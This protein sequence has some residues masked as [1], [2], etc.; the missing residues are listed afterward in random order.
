MTPREW[1][2]QHVAAFAPHMGA[3]PFGGLGSVGDVL[4]GAILYEFEDGP[5]RALVALRP[6]K[7]T[8]GTRCDVVGLVSTGERMRAAVFD[9]GVCEVA[10]RLGA[11]HLAMVT[12]Q[13]HVARQ[14]RRLGW[15]QTGVVM[16]KGLHG[17][18]K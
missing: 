10:Q 17:F 16:T 2:A 11:M 15:H 1:A 9:R 14:C 6:V 13:D 18:A 3:S 7:Q 8:H 12:G 4:G 5:A